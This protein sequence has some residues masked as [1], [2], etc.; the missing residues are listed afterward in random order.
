MS[1]FKPR[2]YLSEIPYPKMNFMSSDLIREEMTRL[3]KKLPNPITI[4]DKIL[5]K[6]DLPVPS[7]YYDEQNWKSLL[8]QISVS[9]QHINLKSVNL[10]LLIKYG[11]GAWRKYLTRLENIQKQLENEK[12]FIENENNEVNKR[13]K[14]NQVEAQKSL[15]ELENKF[16]YHLGQVN[17][18]RKECMKMKFKI[19]RL[20]IAKQSKLEKNK[21]KN[22]TVVI[23]VN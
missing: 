23:P 12:S 9:S 21:V 8:N 17:A 20:H 4:S 3:E 13:R 15:N 11:P 22:K 14:I 10:E 18:L 19:K 5:N 1:K 7:K 16:K 6:F 2:D